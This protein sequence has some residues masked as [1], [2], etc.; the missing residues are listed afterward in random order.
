MTRFLTIA[1]I[2][3]LLMTP[4]MVT[5][6]CKI[7]GTGEVNVISNSFPSLE[8][9]AAAMKKCNREGLKIDYKLTRGIDEESKQALAA[10]KCPYDLAQ[11]ANSLATALQAAGHLQPLNDLVDKYRDTYNIEDGMLIK[12]GDDIIAI[13]FQINAQH[14]YYRK[15]LFEKHNIAVPT[16]YDEVLA[17]AEKLKKEPSI[18]FPLGGTYKSGWNI[19]QEFI[20]MYLG[21]GGEFF[22]PGTAEPAFNS[23]KGVKALEVMEKLMAYMSPNALALDTTAVMQQFQQGQIAMANLWASRA[24]KMDDA[25]ESKVV[26]LIEFAVAPSAVK[27]GPP[28]TTLWWDGFY[29]PR[30]MD[31]DR[32]LAFQVMM[33]GLSEEVVQANN[34]VAIWLRSVYKLTRFS[35][36]AAASA[37]GGA[38]SYPMKPQI[39]LVHA[40]IGANIGDFMAGKESASKSLADAEAAYIKSARE[41]GYIK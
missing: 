10:A 31:G 14:L 32:D 13:A 16:T 5:A 9:I 3:T 30:N 8:V 26:G 18:Q 28:A 21:M 35:K 36:G 19:A 17:A 20:N 23:E 37:M 40:A 41:K 39:P 6:E 34:D 24:P 7:Q 27:G 4:T 12:F 1:M 33:A 22:K 15:D 38:P 2:A 11:G 29:L 25:A